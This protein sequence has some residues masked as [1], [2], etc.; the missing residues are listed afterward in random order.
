[1]NWKMHGRVFGLVL[2]S[3][4][5]VAANASYSIG[6]AQAGA[7][8][9]II[10]AQ[11]RGTAITL[12][13]ERARTHLGSFLHYALDDNGIARDNAAIKIV[14]S[15]HGGDD[16]VVWVSPFAMR[17]GRYVGILAN[18][19]KTTETKHVGDPVAFDA[20]QVRDWYFFG[21]DGKMYGSYTTRVMLTE[22]APNTARQI[23]QILSPTPVPAHWQ[24][25]RAHAPNHSAET[26][27]KPNAD[28]KH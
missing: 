6:P 14:M 5:F 24:D 7:S 10:T 1:M 21:D 12:A 9:P 27:F 2:L 20:A 16:E 22:M 17:D 4:N 19:P 26:D 15:A 3:V 11:T 8:D 18:E 25:R 13:E 28:I 23:T